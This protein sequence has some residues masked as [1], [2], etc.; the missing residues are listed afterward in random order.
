MK[1]KT[2]NK[3][4]EP[5]KK[6]TTKNERALKKK[7]NER[8][9]IRTNLRL[10]RKRRIWEV[11]NSLDV[12]KNADKKSLKKIINDLLTT[13]ETIKNIQ[14]AK[15]IKSAARK[16]FN[17]DDD[18]LVDV[19]MNE[20]G[21][22]EV[23]VK[24]ALLINRI[25]E[26]KKGLLDPNLLNEIGEEN[27]L[28][29]KVTKELYVVAQEA[30]ENKMDDQGFGDIFGKDNEIIND[31]DK[32]L[33]KTYIEVHSYDGEGKSFVAE[34]S[35]YEGIDNGGDDKYISKFRNEEEVNKFQPKNK[36]AQ[37]SY[38]IVGEDYKR[39]K[40]DDENMIYTD[41]NL[42]NKNSINVKEE[43][44]ENNTFNVD[45]KFSLKDRIYSSI[46]NVDSAMNNIVTRLNVMKNVNK[47]VDINNNNFINECGNINA[48]K[49]PNVK[50]QLSEFIK[51]VSGNNIDQNIMYKHFIGIFFSLYGEIERMKSSIC[52]LGDYIKIDRQ[53]KIN[54]EIHGKSNELEKVIV[55]KEIKLKELKD[56]GEFIEEKKWKNMSA[57][58]KIKLRFGLNEFRQNPFFSAWS[59]FKPEEK[60]D[61]IN[62]RANWRIKKAEELLKAEEGNKKNQ[63]INNFFF[64][65]WRDKNGF[66]LP[67]HDI[68][69]LKEYNDK[70]NSCKAINELKEKLNSLSMNHRVQGFII[71]DGNLIPNKGQAYYHNPLYVNRGFIN[72]LNK[73][74]FI[75][76]K[77]FRFN[78]GNAFSK[79]KDQNFQN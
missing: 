22:S 38:R 58:E 12:S 3:V 42:D 69:D 47:A 62:F 43:K 54:F 11:I 64:Y 5:Y 17:D 9:K 40:N 48:D 8:N 7:S 67:T 30:M 6:N 25:Q 34:R 16:Y 68:D 71:C 46:Q 49:L 76:K 36:D 18:A 77:R 79:S 59:N 50:E 33:E 78:F 72:K 39:K 57:Y 21:A 45:K 70:M 2:N 20:P 44:V 52:T 1:A 53:H 74:N 31:I 15:E 13:E 32:Y 27:K 23:S 10:G 75:N 14:N 61:W 24:Q 51:Y 37:F 28:G 29:E 66:S 56:K 63:R 65:E 41:T 26:L 55:S 35:F 73:N 4:S 19:F 60:K